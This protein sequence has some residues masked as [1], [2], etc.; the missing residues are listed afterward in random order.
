MLA[1]APVS[2]VPVPETRQLGREQCDTAEQGAGS[3][4]AVPMD[5]AGAPTTDFYEVPPRNIP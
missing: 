3:W 4:R 2:A 1:W 5:G